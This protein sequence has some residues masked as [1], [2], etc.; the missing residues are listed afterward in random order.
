[1]DGSRSRTHVLVVDSDPSEINRLAKHLDGMFAWDVA[2]DLREAE[3]KI[4]LHHPRVVL[5]ADEVNGTSTL[6]FC[7]KIKSGPARRD[8][9]MVNLTRADPR[10]LYRDADVDIAPTTDDQP[11]YFIE[12]AGR[13]RPAGQGLR[14]LRNDCDSARPTCFGNEAPGRTC[15][16]GSGIGRMA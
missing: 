16:V 11:F 13:N 15:C 4:T 12:R 2:G 10:D 5:I 3:R 6:D 1:M 14:L 7:R 9:V 8:Q